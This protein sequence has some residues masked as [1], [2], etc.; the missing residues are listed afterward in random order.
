MM[1]FQSQ[2]DINFFSGRSL[3]EFKAY[4]HGS[5][6]VLVSQLKDANKDLHYVYSEG[7]K[8]TDQMMNQLWSIYP[9]TNNPI[10][11]F[12]FVMPKQ[13]KKKFVLDLINCCEEYLKGNKIKIHI[14]E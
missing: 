13:E 8:S 12:S 11:T 14:F 7:W 10:K 4:L 2:N 5:N 1:C 6:K 9:F 3:A